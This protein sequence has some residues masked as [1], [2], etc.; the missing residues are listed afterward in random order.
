MRIKDGLRRVDIFATW[1]NT[2]RG[3]IKR[4]AENIKQM[5]GQQLY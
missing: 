5:V 3:S 4:E 1:N 2:K